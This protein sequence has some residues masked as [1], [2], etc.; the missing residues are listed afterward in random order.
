MIRPKK[1]LGFTLTEII[2]TLM[3]LCILGGIAIPTYKHVMLKTR[4]NDAK[5]TLIHM[6]ARLEARYSKEQ[7]YLDENDIDPSLADLGVQS[8][9]Q[10]YTFSMNVTS[11]TYTL[12]ATPMD[13]QAKWDTQ[14]GV[15]TLNQSG[16]KGA[17]GKNQDTNGCW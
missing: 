13:S 1:L 10:D 9:H 12:Y 15:L 11:D 6:A 5:A 8:P 16:T 14:C 4:R 7:S 3:I 2:V 17:Q